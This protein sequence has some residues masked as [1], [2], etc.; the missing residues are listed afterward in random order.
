M[1][2]ITKMKEINK[3]K[4]FH[5]FDKETM[6]FF[7]SRIEYAPNK[8]NFFITSEN[9]FTGTKRAYTVRWFDTE[10][11]DVLTVPP[12]NKLTKQEALYLRED[13]TEQIKGMTNEQIREY[14]HSMS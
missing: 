9:D 4:G 7:S 2:T 3:A 10:V 13:V 12:F 14:I 8:A 1:L 11:G 5:F 6:K